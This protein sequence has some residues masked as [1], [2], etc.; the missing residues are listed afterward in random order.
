M[1]FDL[2][3]VEQIEADGY[4]DM[5]RAVSMALPELDERQLGRVLSFLA[6]VCFSCWTIDCYGACMRDE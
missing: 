6:A 2:M 1:D 5:V 3:T 4:G